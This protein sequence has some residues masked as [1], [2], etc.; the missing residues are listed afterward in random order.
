METKSALQSLS[1]LAQDHRL[2]IFR[3]LVTR[4]TLGA[5][6]QEIAESVGFGGSTLSFHLKGLV[7]A[8][9]ASATSEGRFV[10]YHANFAAMDGLIRY[11]T[12]HCCEDDPGRCEIAAKTPRTPKGGTRA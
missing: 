11:L 9:L 1:G 10:R 6:V 8:G 12:E 3:Y 7:H 5:V 4:G 2:S